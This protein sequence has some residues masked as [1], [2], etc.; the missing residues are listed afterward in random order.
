MQ[1]EKIKVPQLGAN[2]IVTSHNKEYNLDRTSEIEDKMSHKE[3]KNV[4][5]KPKKEHKR[6]KKVNQEKGIRRPIKI[7]SIDSPTSS[8]PLT[9]KIVNETIHK[10]DTFIENKSSGVD[11]EKKSNEQLKLTSNSHKR[12][13]VYLTPL[14]TF[15]LMFEVFPYMEIERNFE[16]FKNF[17][18]IEQ[19]HKERKHVHTLSS[20]ISNTHTDKN[21]QSESQ[22]QNLCV[23]PG[24]YQA[25]LLKE[26]LSVTKLT[27]AV[28]YLEELIGRMF[29]KK[30]EYFVEFAEILEP[31]YFILKTVDEELNVLKF[32]NQN[33]NK[34]N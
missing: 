18:K 24:V 15:N 21:I 27:L 3:N 25:K 30:D 32:I 14:E 1:G 33:P 20:L 28:E 7:R 5:M 16:F 22:T 4:H 11:Y 8:L 19:I 12:K 9:E 6:S 29:L 31:L 10:V 23:L 34:H 17:K 26:K 13:F 2:S